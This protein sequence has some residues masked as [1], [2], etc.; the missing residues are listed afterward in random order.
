[1][2]ACPI[3]A[4]TA[5]P[6]PQRPFRRDQQPGTCK[7]CMNRLG[8]DGDRHA[9]YCPCCGERLSS[10]CLGTRRGPARC[11]HC[12]RI[13]VG[14]L[15]FMPEP[16][17]LAMLLSGSLEPSAE[18]TASQL[19]RAVFGDQ[20]AFHISWSWQ[21]REM[22]CGQLSVRGHEIRLRL[23]RATQVFEAASS[24]TADQCRGRRWSIVAD[25]AQLLALHTHGPRS[26]T[27]PCDRC[28]PTARSRRAV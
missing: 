11:P 27:S 21:D 15:A 9:H 18:F 13:D 1:M 25:S 7:N 28:G 16:D 24:C 20:V 3:H 4:H 22:H 10:G 17:P 23:H 26:A 12:G 6:R 19:A 14:T 5:S 2:T 8:T